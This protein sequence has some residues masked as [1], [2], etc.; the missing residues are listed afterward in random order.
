MTKSLKSLTDDYD[1][2][3]HKDLDQATLLRNAV[4]IKKVSISFIS[5]TILK[6]MK[7]VVLTSLDHYDQKATRVISE[8]KARREEEMHAR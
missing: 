6:A 7:H 2:K 4:E 3:L 1:G 8:V 5:L